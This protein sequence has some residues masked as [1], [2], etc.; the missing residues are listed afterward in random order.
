MGYI[1]LSKANYFHNLQLLS[2]KLGSVERLAV[3]LK[4]NAYGHGL[5][6]MATLAK[7][8]G[9]TRAIVRNLAE[10]KQIEGMFPFIMILVPEGEEESG[11]FS[12]VINSLEALSLMP[13]GAKIHLKVDSGMHRSGIVVA[14]LAEAFIMIEQRGLVL[15]GVMTHFRSADELSCE[16]FWQMRVW[17]EIKERVLKLVK[18]HGFQR[19]LFHSA[20]S[21][22][23]LRLSTYH[24]D[25]AR[26]GIASYGYEESH[27]TLSYSRLKPVLQLWANK[28]SS[29]FL[30]KGECVGYGGV[31]EL[32]SDAVVSTY[33]IG[34]GDGYFRYDGKGALCTPEGFQIVGRVSMDNISVISQKKQL[35]LLED[36]KAVAH[37]HDTISYDVLVKLSAF[38]KRIVV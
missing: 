35:L 22:A 12:L 27:E 7:E 15:E 17:E 6:Q 4:D 23:L 1:T 33:D 29:R 16:L 28:L 19:P 24:D 2:D 30:H 3:V 18:K 11:A 20:N 36:A 14:E 5:V 34:Y 38:L 32:T 21:A 8:F 10:A 26:C 25:F 37:Y 13:H 31:G 9:V